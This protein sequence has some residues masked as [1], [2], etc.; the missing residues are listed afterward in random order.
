MDRQRKTYIFERE[1]ISLCVCAHFPCLCVHTLHVCA[2]VCVHTLHVPQCS[3]LKF[4]QQ[5][6]PS[7]VGEVSEAYAVRAQACPVS[8]SHTHTHTHLQNLLPDIIPTAILA[9]TTLCTCTTACG[10]RVGMC[11]VWCLQG[12]NS[13]KNRT[14][15]GALC[16]I[17]IPERHLTRREKGEERVWVVKVCYKIVTGKK[18]AALSHYGSVFAMFD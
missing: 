17:V 5:Q 14:E 3:G 12:G 15:E 2:C 4:L 1:K 18:W 9:T 16:D 6:S 8:L 11:G 7:P 13:H 10:S